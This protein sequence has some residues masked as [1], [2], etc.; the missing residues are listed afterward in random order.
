MGT[1]DEEIERLVKKFNWNGFKREGPKH[2]V[3]VPPFDLGKYPVTQAQ[4]RAIADRNDLKVEKDLD[5]DPSHFKNPPLAPPSKGEESKALFFKGGL[6]EA[7]TRW[8]RP[9]EQVNWYDAI[10]FCARLS[11]LTGKEYRLPTEAEWE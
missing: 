1:E 7:P 2:R 3:T 10:E 6:G 11:K 5:P 8:D 4:W 9:V